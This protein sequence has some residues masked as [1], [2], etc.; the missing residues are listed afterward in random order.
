[1]LHSCTETTGHSSTHICY[2]KPLI[3]SIQGRLATETCAIERGVY[4]VEL[5]GLRKEVYLE[6]L[7]VHVM[8]QV[9][10]HLQ[11]HNVSHCM[12]LPAKP[13][14]AWTTCQIRIG[15]LQ[16]TCSPTFH[17]S[18]PTCQ[19]KE[20]RNAPNLQIQSHQVLQTT[21][22]MTCTTSPTSYRF[23]VDP[24]QLRSTNKSYRGEGSSLLD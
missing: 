22:V 8:T 3:M 1:M 2:Q 14:D 19:A 6:L 16:L 5:G 13:Q 11:P 4:P 20:F 21:G 23:L 24:L 15:L 10:K 18:Q 7:L 9:H 12:N 17:D